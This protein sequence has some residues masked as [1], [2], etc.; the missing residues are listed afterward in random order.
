M[1]TLVVK[2]VEVVIFGAAGEVTSAGCRVE[3]VLVAFR[4]Q[5]V[6]T[7]VRVSVVKMVVVRRA[8]GGV[9]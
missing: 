1:Y 3:A 6:V 2:T 5:I 8:D 9:L 4:G 7:E